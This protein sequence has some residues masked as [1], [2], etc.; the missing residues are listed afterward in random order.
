[1]TRKSCICKTNIIYQS[2]VV[3][4]L[5]LAPVGEDPNIYQWA[6]IPTYTNGRGF[7]HIPVGGDTNIY[8]WV[9]IPIY[10]SGWGFPM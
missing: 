5:M 9:G 8:Q 1:M 4:S 2:F 7:Q 10:T 6:R 3:K